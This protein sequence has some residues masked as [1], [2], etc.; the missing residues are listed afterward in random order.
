LLGASPKSSTFT[1][2]SDLGAPDHHRN[3]ISRASLLMSRSR[4]PGHGAFARAGLLFSPH[5]KNVIRAV[6]D[7]EAAPSRS[8]A[9]QV[10]ASEVLIPQVRSDP[11][12]ERATFPMTRNPRGLLRQRRPP[13]AR[14]LGS[15]AFTI[16]DGRPDSVAAQ[17]KL[18]RHRWSSCTCDPRT[19]RLP[20]PPLAKKHAIGTVY[21]SGTALRRGHGADRIRALLRSDSQH[22]RPDSGFGRHGHNHITPHY[23]SK[24]TSRPV[25][26]LLNHPYRRTP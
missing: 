2:L 9:P 7:T 23:Q 25:Q 4:M 5:L 22:L 16:S 17:K 18:D 19:R 8:A 21:L 10:D 13:G 24:M 1:V 20:I 26:P 11:I 12:R 6:C 14:G 15:K 3:K